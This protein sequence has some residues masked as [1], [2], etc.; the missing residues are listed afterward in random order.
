M[1]FASYVK[2]AVFFL[3]L[4]GAGLGYMLLTT[5]GINPLNTRTFEAVFSDAMGI[6]TRSL[7]YLAGVP[8]GQVQS[9]Q[10]D[11]AEARVR[12][13]VLNDV[14]LHQDAFISRQASSL[15][16]TS[17][18][19]LHPGTELTPIIPAGSTIG[20]GP[21]AGDI[22]TALNV[23]QD[24]GSQVHGILD[25]FRMNQM[26]LLAVSLESIG[27][28]TQRIDAQS[29]E[30][31]DHI[32]RILESVALI[33]ERSDRILQASE[34]NI[35]G[36]FADIHQAMANIRA[37]TGEAAEGRGNVGQA[38]F[39]DRLYQSILATAERTEEIADRL[40]EALGNISL[41]VQNVDGVVT[42]AGEIVDRALGL[43][44][45]IDT[46][47]RYDFISETARAS[48][49]LRLEPRSGDRWYRV[50]VSSVPDGVAGSRTS[51]TFDSSG[52]LLSREETRSTIGID[53]E[54]ARRFGA[55]TVRGGV[56]ESTAGFGMDLHA[57]NW[58]SV[59]GEI[60]RFTE[61]AAPNLRSTVTFYPFFNPD[62]DRPLN[63]LYLRTGI[64]NALSG[65]RDYFIGGGL[66]FSDREIRGLV[67]L[68][69]IFN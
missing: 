17:V 3:A 28:I 19:S 61:G 21:A 12:F 30:Q 1:K 20:T 2:I 55:L 24:I 31:L 48:A 38:F 45:V 22:A 26:A 66:R 10:L 15:L 50:G 69:P 36:S 6:S 32:S 16:G 60:F 25:E 39:D 37:I 18:L 64:T 54:L 41:L 4:G 35:T 58:L 13:A 56:L 52:V 51:E 44:I 8:V 5:S 9:I 34:G 47:A 57:F 65:D 33:A 62:S 7:V 29:A 67:G 42:N 68:A 23:V 40:G 63:W 53:A 46:S 14:P 43:G 11:G 59:S 27:S 49:S